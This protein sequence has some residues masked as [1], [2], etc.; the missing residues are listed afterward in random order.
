[1]VLTGLQ[2]Y[3]PLPENAFKLELII[4]KRPDAKG[5]KTVNRYAEY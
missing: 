5:L 3:N 4:K 1:M 2:L